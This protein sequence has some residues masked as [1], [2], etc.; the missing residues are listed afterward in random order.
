VALNNF[1]LIDN[2]RGRGDYRFSWIDLESGVSALVP[3]NPLTLFRF[4]LPKSVRH[5]RALFDDV[6]ISKLKA[7]I[8]LHQADIHLH[9]GKPSYTQLLQWL[10]S[11]AYH[12]Q[13]WKRMRRVERSV[14]YQLKK[15]NIR[16]AEAEWF[17]QHPLRWYWRELIRITPRVFYTFVIQL[18]RKVL[19]KLRSIDYIQF[20]RRSWLSI[21]SQ[22]YRLHLAQ[23]YVYERISHWEQRQQLTSEE[24]AYL[25]AEL[26]DDEAG[27]YLMDFGVHPGSKGLDFDL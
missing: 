13:S 26:D 14:T 18:P 1:L 17:I 15:G 22:A 7:Y 9:I 19:N 10:E 3:I 8:A 12:Q 21:T 5:R 4:Y 16:P 20:V 25:A 11:L 24:A 6:D 23:E 2:E 27:D